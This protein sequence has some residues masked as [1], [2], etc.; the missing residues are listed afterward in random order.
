[1]EAIGFQDAVHAY[2]A[3]AA[4]AG[5]V[6][7]RRGRLAPGMDADLVVWSA[8]PNGGPDDGARFLRGGALLTVVDGEVVMRR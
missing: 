1:E 6:A 5:G 4:S 3:A 8:V 2:T 7:A